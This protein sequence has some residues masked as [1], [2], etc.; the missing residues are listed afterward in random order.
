MD[1]LI[2]PVAET[3]AGN[4]VALLTPILE[5]GIYSAMVDPGSVEDQIAF[6]RNRPPLGIYHLAE[7]AGRILGIQDVDP[8]ATGPE[9]V[10]E[11]S[12]FVALGR[13]RQ[14]IGGALTRATLAEARTRGYRTLHATIRADNPD[15]LAF[16]RRQGFEPVGRRRITVR[17]LVRE[18]IITRL[19][20]DSPPPAPL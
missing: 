20:L 3:D 14:G 1:I 18:Q 8:T 11:I 5:A 9:P 12:T 19:R 16:Y 4:I 17:N 15:A 10:G 13:H 7:S 2:R 6:I